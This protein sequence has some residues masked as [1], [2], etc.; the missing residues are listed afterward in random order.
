MNKY[1][2]RIYS[3]CFLPDICNRNAGI[4]GSL[5]TK[6]R[7]SILAQSFDSGSAQPLLS[8]SINFDMIL[9]SFLDFIAILRDFLKNSLTIH[10]FYLYNH[11]I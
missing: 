8:V 4:S 10:Q 3:S 5:Q 6:T 1:T 11:T 7:I 2:E 9:A